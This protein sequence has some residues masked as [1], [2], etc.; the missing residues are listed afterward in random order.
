MSTRALFAAGVAVVEAREQV[1][2]DTGYVAVF[3]ATER[4]LYFLVVRVIDNLHF[5]QCSSCT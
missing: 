1:M 4:K 2:F 5:N 3:M